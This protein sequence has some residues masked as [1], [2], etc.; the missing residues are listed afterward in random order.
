MEIQVKICTAIL[1]FIILYTLIFF[2]F[3]YN[4]KCGMFICTE[5]IESN[6]EYTIKGYNCTHEVDEEWK[7][8]K[9]EQLDKV[10]IGSFYWIN[11]QGF[12]GKNNFT[13]M[14]LEDAFAIIKARDNIRSGTND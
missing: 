13:E 7:L 2:C 1:L 6:G 4:F 12:F 11:K 5:I 14:S 10:K 9:V 3:I 8:N